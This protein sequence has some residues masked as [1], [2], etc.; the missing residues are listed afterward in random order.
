MTFLMS[1]C[2]DQ[3][4]QP[5]AWSVPYEQWKAKGFHD[6]TI[7][8]TRL[9][10]CISGGETMRVTIR[11]GSIT[12]VARLSDTTQVSPSIS[13][14]YLTV[15]SLFGK[16]RSPGSDSIVVTYNSQFGYPERV[17]INPQYHPV[18]GGVIYE[19]SN[20]QVP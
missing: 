18:D 6:Y 10:F 11:S 4:S 8:Q 12:S 13:S 2:K 9:C 14:L 3:G 1:G 17:D 20:L 16:I 5:P 7:D 19:T 15:D